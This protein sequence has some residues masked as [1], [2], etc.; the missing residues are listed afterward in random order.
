MWEPT[1]C[2]SVSRASTNDGAVTRYAPGSTARRFA[3][4]STGSLA[5]RGRDHYGRARASQVHGCSSGRAS[6]RERASLR[7][8]RA[9]VSV[10]VRV[11]RL[12]LRP[13]G[14][15]QFDG[16]CE[17]DLADVGRESPAIFRDLL[18]VTVRWVD[19]PMHRLDGAEHIGGVEH[20][21]STTDRGVELRSLGRRI[22]AARARS[23]SR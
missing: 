7:S 8:P 19:L 12:L 17:D 3:K 13:A 18:V 1:I 9:S 14:R 20:L 11:A 6:G 22:L 23:P 4:P 10:Q 15:D 2:H 16:E 21:R 5:F